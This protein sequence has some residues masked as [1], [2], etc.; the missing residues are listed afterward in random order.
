[1]PYMI[2]C[3]L[4]LQPISIFSLDPFCTGPFPTLPMFSAIELAG[5][6]RFRTSITFQGVFTSLPI[7][8]GLLLA[9]S[10]ASQ[11]SILNLSKHMYFSLVLISG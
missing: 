2:R 11:F 8:I 7:R 1:M 5:Q 4:A 9:L 10:Q 6:G 3:F